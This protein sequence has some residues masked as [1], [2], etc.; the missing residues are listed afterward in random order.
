M[1]FTE[2]LLKL[3][4]PWDNS[5]EQLEIA[6]RL[7]NDGKNAQNEGNYVEARTLM[8]QSLNIYKKFGNKVKSV[9]VLRNLS[10]IAEVQN[11]YSQARIYLN[12]SLKL[13]QILNNPALVGTI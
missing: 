12:Q 8:E 11:D 1:A 13:N 5:S 2:K 7:F 9:S 10:K 6:A 4:S 3:N